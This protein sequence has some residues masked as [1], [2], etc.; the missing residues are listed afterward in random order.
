VKTSLEGNA[1]IQESVKSTLGD[2]KDSDG[3]PL[4]GYADG[5]LT[6][7]DNVDLSGF[8]PA[9]Q[10]FAGRYKELINSQS[11][12]IEVAIVNMNEPLPMLNGNSLEQ[13]GAIGVTRQMSASGRTNS[14]YVGDNPKIHIVDKFTIES[15]TIQVAIARDPSRTETSSGGYNAL[16]GHVSETRSTVPYPKGTSGFTSVH[17]ILGHAFEEHKHAERFAP[18]TPQGVS[19]CLF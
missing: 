2:V 9:Q 10:E 3:N 18:S 17:E 7:N 11:T 16:G 1:T 15:Q 12:I 13:I 19:G 14:M 6:Y 4:I 8:N 5:K